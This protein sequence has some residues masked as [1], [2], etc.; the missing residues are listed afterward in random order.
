MQFDQEKND[1]RIL[2]IENQLNSENLRLKE[3]VN[4]FKAKKASLNS[5]LV[6]TKILFETE[7]IILKRYINLLEVGAIAEIQM[8]QQK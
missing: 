7:S 6:S 2:S 1:S 8:L 3:E 4:S 5:K